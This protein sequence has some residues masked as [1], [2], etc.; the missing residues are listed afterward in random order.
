M[1]AKQLV[2]REH[3]H[4]ILFEY[5]LHLVVADNLSFVIWI[6]QVVCF[7]V[8]PYLLYDLWPR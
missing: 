1:L 8:L 7:D 6:L 4:L 3:M 5:K 2:H